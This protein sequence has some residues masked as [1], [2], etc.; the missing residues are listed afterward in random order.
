MAVFRAQQCLIMVTAKLE[1]KDMSGNMQLPHVREL[2]HEQ[3]MVHCFF[4]S[5]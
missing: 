5:R 2:Y 4:M 1:R 3:E